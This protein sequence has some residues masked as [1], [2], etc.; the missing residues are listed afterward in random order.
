VKDGNSR[1]ITAEE[2]ERAGLLQSEI[3]KGHKGRT[4][5]KRKKERQ[6]RVVK[7]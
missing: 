3:R 2:N 6:K 4:K 1:A 5:K 7:G